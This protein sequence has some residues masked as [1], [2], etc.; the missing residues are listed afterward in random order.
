MRSLGYYVL[1]YS[2]KDYDEKKGETKKIGPF[3]SIENAWAR[4]IAVEE[5]GKW[6]HVEIVEKCVIGK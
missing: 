5:T 2:Q 6:R 4:K 3:K 1:C